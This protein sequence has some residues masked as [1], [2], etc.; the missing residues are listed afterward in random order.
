MQEI[1]I[2]QGAQKIWSSDT[3]GTVRS[4]DV[5][6]FEPNSEREYRVTWNGRDASKCAN[7]QAAGPV[8]PAGEYEV[9]GRLSARLSAPVKLVLGG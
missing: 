2:K 9:I 8:P 4:S 7:A 1:Y 3:C 5:K 6:Q